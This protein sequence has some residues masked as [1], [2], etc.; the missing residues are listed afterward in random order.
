[1]CVLTYE[2]GYEKPWMVTSPN[3]TKFFATLWGA[4]DYA[5]QNDWIIYQLSGRL[6]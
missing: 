5:D 3:G 1:M 2:H 6:A 4:R